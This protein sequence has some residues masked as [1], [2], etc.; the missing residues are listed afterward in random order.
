MT[1][2]QARARMRT[3]WGWSWPRARARSVEVGGPGVGASGVGG[4]VGD[5]VAELFVAGPAESDDADLAGLA[6]RG[7]C[8]G[9]TGQRFGGGESG[10]AVADL[11]E[12]PGGPD[13][14]GAGQAGEDVGVGVG[15]ELV[16][17]VGRERFDLVDQGVQ[18]RDVAAR[19]TWPGGG[20]FAGGSA[21][22]VESGVGAAPW[23]R[24]SPE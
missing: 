9:Q 14:A 1:W 19:V 8:A 4:E 20:V 3:A 6:G 5:G 22:R 13:A 24:P 10:A 16:V 17:D 7:C 23:G 18:Q 11:G 15:V 21:R 2:S 12:Q